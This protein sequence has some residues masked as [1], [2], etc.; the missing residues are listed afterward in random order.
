M[1]TN[2]TPINASGAPV[3]PASQTK[4]PEWVSQ[5][6]ADFE[7]VLDILDDG[8][9][10]ENIKL[11]RIEYLELKRHLAE[12]RGYEI[13]ETEDK[14]A[15]TEAADPTSGAAAELISDRLT[16]DLIED[17]KGRLDQVAAF[18]AKLAPEVPRLRA[19]FQADMLLLR[20]IARDWESEYGADEFP[21]ETRLIAA[22][23][24]NLD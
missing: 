13:P 9:F 2:A 22:I 11:T 7:Y 21:D 1:E 15:P 17:I 6:P 20:E 19:E 3:R 18:N 5:T 8:L 12:M 16:A 14:T 23:R 4:L 10:L 24:A